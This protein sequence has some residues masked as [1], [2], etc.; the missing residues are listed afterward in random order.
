MKWLDIN[1]DLIDEVDST[2]SIIW[3]RKLFE[4][5]NVEIHTSQFIGD[6][7]YVYNDLIDKTAVITKGQTDVSGFIVY[8]GYDLRHIL[9]DKVVWKSISYE[10]VTIEDIIFDLLNQFS[11][12]NF[13]KFESVET[14]STL[15]LQITAGNLGDIINTVLSGSNLYLEIE[16]DYDNR[17]LYYIL[18]EVIDNS[19]NKQ[20]LS[21]NYETISSESIVFDRENYRNYAYVSGIDGEIVEVDFRLNSSDERK[22]IFVDGSGLVKEIDGVTIPQAT[23][24]SQLYELGKIELKKYLISDTIVLDI[25]PL[26]EVELGEIRTYQGDF[27][28]ATKIIT[29][30]IYGYEKGTQTQEIVF[31]Q[32]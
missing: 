5:G 30:L 20:P 15:N 16:Y 25:T 4:K 27:I 29:E 17:K 7:I 19:L 9:A 22:E 11:S 18:G 14:K 12:Y 24:L 21:L 23:Y 32:E 2:A 28:S 26:A 13:E 1:F 6:L 3:H 10:N 31:N 8:S